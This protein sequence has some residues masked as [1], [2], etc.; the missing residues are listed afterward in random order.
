[1]VPEKFLLEIYL[2]LSN[3]KRK[4]FVT[5]HICLEQKNV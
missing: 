1:M 2:F 3:F 4:W 5:W